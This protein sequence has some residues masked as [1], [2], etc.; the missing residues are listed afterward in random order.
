LSFLNKTPLNVPKSNIK[1]KYKTFKF[2][3][4]TNQ[5][6]YSQFT[7]PQQYNIPAIITACTFVSLLIYLT[8][9]LLLVFLLQPTNLSSSFIIIGAFL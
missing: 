1:N 5:K 8:Q 3:K 6:L 7:A 9:L 2:N 4:F